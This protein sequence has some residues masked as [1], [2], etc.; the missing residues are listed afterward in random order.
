[1]DYLP[2]QEELEAG[3]KDADHVTCYDWLYNK[4][5]GDGLVICPRCNVG[6]VKRFLHQHKHADGDV[7]QSVEYRCDQRGYC[8]A[9]FPFTRGTIFYRT[10]TMHHWFK[11]LYEIRKWPRI[12][13]KQLAHRVGTS[14]RIA[15]KM[16]KVYLDEAVKHL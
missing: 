4:L 5:Y 3:L 1:M 11:T 10:T 14:P 12:G 13:N 16:A 9:W 2:T 15:G 6:T 7:Y 8:G